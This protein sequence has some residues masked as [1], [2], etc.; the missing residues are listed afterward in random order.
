MPGALG[1]KP[2]PD[3]E[4]V[5][6]YPLSAAL[7]AG[8]VAPRPVVIGVNWYSNFD[9]PVRDSQGHYWIGKSALGTV[10]GGHCVALKQR[11]AVDTTGWYDFYDQGTE[12]A[13]VGFG[14]SRIM[15]LMNRKR[16][17]ARW[18][19]DRAKEID[20]WDDTNPGDDN[21]TLVRSALQVLKDKGHVPYST[22]YDVINRDGHGEDWKSRSMLT[23]KLSEGI[24][25]FRWIR[26]V[27]DC[28]T[29]L[30][31]GGLDY[32]DVIN[33]WGRGYPHLTRLPA[34]TL[35]RLWHEDGEIGV[36][37]DR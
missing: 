10:R 33:S 22:K 19:W 30:G 6:K 13:C 16:Y 23:P 25:A 12:G 3:W 18:L 35:E 7:V 2:P 36:V 32:V 29:V 28:L 8:I 5:D 31:Y 24:D 9:N 11:G 4:H 26:S 14:S 17:F 21:G 15:S 34:S 27:D 1:R 20:P 37:T